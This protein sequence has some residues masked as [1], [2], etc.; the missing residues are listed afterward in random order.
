MTTKNYPVSAIVS[1]TFKGDSFD[2]QI[3]KFSGKGCATA[4]NSEFVS[5]T[6]TLGDSVASDLPSGTKSVDYKSSSILL[7]ILD[8]EAIKEANGTKLCG[9]E[10]WTYDT[11]DVTLP[12]GPQSGGCKNSRG[13][14]YAFFARTQYGR[15]LGSW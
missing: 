12:Y 2:S 13:T 15:V 1:V 4:Y 9:F 14:T 11:R 10:D 6:F 8:A 5:E 7:Q 3:Q